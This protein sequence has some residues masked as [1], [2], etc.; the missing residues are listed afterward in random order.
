MG[1]EG[2]CGVRSTPC[3]HCCLG[4]SVLQDLLTPSLVNKLCPGPAVEPS[5]EYV[6]DELH[7]HL[8]QVCRI[9]VVLHN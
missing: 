6:R 1:E 9:M 7:L 5:A 3:N 4:L 2:V 8:C